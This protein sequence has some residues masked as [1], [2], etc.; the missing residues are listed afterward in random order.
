MENLNLKCPECGA[1]ITEKPN[2]FECQNHAYD[3]KTKT[4]SGCSFVI[5]KQLLNKKISAKTLAKLLNN[6]V[7]QVNNFINLK[8]KNFDAGIKLVKV[9]DEN[10]YKIEL[11]FDD[12]KR[13][14]DKNLE[15]I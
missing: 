15:E 2:I 14:N 4:A 3:F 1:D 10:K 9:P 5:F 12:V 7:V 6:D 11:I 13:D 8:G